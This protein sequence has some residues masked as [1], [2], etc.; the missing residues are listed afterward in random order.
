MEKEQTETAQKPEETLSLEEQHEREH[1][2][3]GKKAEKS[4][5]AKFHP[6]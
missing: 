6:E 4:E 3:N 1:A 5:E 2:W